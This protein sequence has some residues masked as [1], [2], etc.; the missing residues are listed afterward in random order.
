MAL[1]SAELSRV[2]EE[3]CRV[4]GE[5]LSRL[6]VEELCRLEVEDVRVEVMALASKLL[7]TIS[8]S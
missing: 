4:E 5:E 6:E 1:Y 3:L 2:E 8:L 7:L